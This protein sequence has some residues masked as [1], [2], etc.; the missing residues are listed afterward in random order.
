MGLSEYKIFY[1]GIVGLIGIIAGLW[2]VLTSAHARYDRFFSL[3]NAFGGGVFL[4]AALIHLLPDSIESLDSLLG[5][6]LEY[7]LA[8]LICTTGFLLVL[9]IEKVIVR[10][11]EGRIVRAASVRRYALA[12]YVLALILSVHSIIAG[13]ALGAESSLVTSAALFT[14]IIA[15]KGVAGF[16]LG[17]SIRNDGVA[18]A[19]AIGLIALFAAMTLWVSQSARFLADCCPTKGPNGS[20]GSSMGWR[21]EPFSTSPSWT[22]LKASSPNQRMLARSSRWCF[23]ALPSWRLSP[24]GPSAETIFGN[25]G[26]ALGERQWWAREGS[27]LQPDGYEPSALTN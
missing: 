2:P 16:A 5:P 10:E 4:G 15:H 24:S 21:P 23:L 8:S 17:V 3:C 18:R 1:I 25:A 26:P 13:M 12:P 27:N 22:S 14:A 9:L 19:Q 7:P 6:S 11:G 20:K